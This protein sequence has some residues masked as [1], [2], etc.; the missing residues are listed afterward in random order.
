MPK[1]LILFAD[2]GSRGN[3]GDSACGFVLYEFEGKNFSQ[4]N[5]QNIVEFENSF[6]L[7]EK[8]GQFGRRIYFKNLFG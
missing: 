2:G 6:R 5:N 7:I 8:K 1:N 4:L 3:P